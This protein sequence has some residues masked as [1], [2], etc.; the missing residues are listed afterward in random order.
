MY[1]HAFSFEYKFDMQTGRQQ[2]YLGVRWVGTCV[3]GQG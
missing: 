3:R 1:E 2:A